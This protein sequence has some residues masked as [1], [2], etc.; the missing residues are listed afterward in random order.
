MIKS[1]TPPNWK[2]IT[3]TFTGVNRNGNVVFAYYPNIH[4]PSGKPL[5]FML[6]AHEKVHLEQQRSYEGGASAWWDRYCEDMKFR[7]SQELPAHRAEYHA[8]CVEPTAN[9]HMRRAVLKVIAKRLSS[10]LYGHM[11]PY[12]VALS[13]LP[14]CDDA[15]VVKRVLEADYDDKEFSE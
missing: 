1:T 8:V 4:V 13:L 3:D 15:A 11:I 14:A 12:K 5:P 10:E 6:L 2:Q 7:L 9:R